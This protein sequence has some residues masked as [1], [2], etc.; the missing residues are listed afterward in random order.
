MKVKKYSE[1]TKMVCPDGHDPE[2]G[3]DNVWEF[4]AAFAGTMSKEHTPG[5]LKV[6][7]GTCGK[8]LV[9]TKVKHEYEQ[10]ICPSCKNQIPESWKY[11]SFCGSKLPPASDM[12][13]MFHDI[14]TNPPTL[15]EKGKRSHKLAS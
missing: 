10:N 6:Y 4:A 3:L 2:S 15:K 13:A 7:C 14:V 11:C 8:K 5:T 9:E 12:K 1:G